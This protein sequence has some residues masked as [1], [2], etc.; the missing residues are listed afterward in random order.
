M[1]KNTSDILVDKVT[2][3]GLSSILQEELN[4]LEFV[5][6]RI[7]IYEELLSNVK[8]PFIFEK[9]KLERYNKRKR[10]MEDILDRLYN[11]K[12]LVTEEISSLYEDLLEE[13]ES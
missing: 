6:K 13:K 3:F 7:A 8:K 10:E 11:E 1:N 12:E 5:N 2:E 9:K 4:G